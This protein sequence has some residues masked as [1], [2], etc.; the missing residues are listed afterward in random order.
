MR[1]FTEFFLFMVIL[2]VFFTFLCF[3]SVKNENSL[4]S[5]PKT[6]LSIRKNI[7]TTYNA[8]EDATVVKYDLVDTDGRILCTRR[9]VNNPFVN[10]SGVIY[11]PQKGIYDCRGEKLRILKLDEY[12]NGVQM[13][14]IDSGRALRIIVDHNHYI[15]NLRT[16]EISA[17]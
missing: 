3:F 13:F 1:K 4:R 8:E 17:G 14:V 9:Q 12:F 10:E 15:Y 11:I 2:S 16:K 6:N 5:V 7:H